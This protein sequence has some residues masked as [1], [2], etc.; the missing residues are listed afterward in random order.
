VVAWALLAGCG[1]APAG[2]PA[3]RGDEPAIEPDRDFE[4]RLR[5][6]AARYLRCSA[7]AVELVRTDWVGSQG[8]YLATG[9]GWRLTYVVVCEAP[10]HCGFTLLE[11]PSVRGR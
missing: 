5:W 8:G 6:H 4:R 10:R 7:A 11:D 2:A 1:G 3:A 9:C